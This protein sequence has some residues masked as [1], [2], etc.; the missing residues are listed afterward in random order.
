MNPGYT[1]AGAVTAD[2]F[3]PPS[4]LRYSVPLVTTAPVDAST[5]C[6]LPEEK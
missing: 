3:R 1:F 6:G 4:T 5:N 2:Q